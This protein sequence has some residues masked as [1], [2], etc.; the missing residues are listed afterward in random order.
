MTTSDISSVADMT[1]ARPPNGRRFLLVA[2]G[3]GA[4]VGSVYSLLPLLVL[5]SGGASAQVGLLIAVV[6]VGMAIGALGGGRFAG[7]HGADATLAMAIVLDLAGILIFLVPLPIVATAIGCLPMGAGVGLFWVASQVRLGQGSPRGFVRHYAAYT[8]GSAIGGPGSG[9]LVQSIAAGANE[10]A[11]EVRAAFLLAVLALA[12][13][14][15]CWPMRLG[16]LR[17]TSASAAELTRPPAAPVVRRTM[18]ILRRG[19]SLQLADLALV[20]GFNAM[21]TIYAVV[22]RRDFRTEPAFIGLVAGGVAASKV[23]GGLV[24]RWLSARI[25][26][27]SALVALSLAGALALGLG[28]LVHDRALFIVSVLLSILLGLGQWPLLVAVA[29]R[30]MPTEHRSAYVGSWNLREF[31]VIAVASATFGWGLDAMPG[32]RATVLLVGAGVLAIGA[33]FTWRLGGI[34]DVRSAERGR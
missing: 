14:A 33:C 25:G 22:L 31:M 28:G 17:A 1:A 7:R 29:M 26:E 10:T 2:F 6:T 9:V 19:A 4:S 5:A 13:S 24:G 20:V 30:H 27:R 8:T 3:V 16:R 32:G 21:L 18:R 15:I 12:L 34:A 23:V 11:G